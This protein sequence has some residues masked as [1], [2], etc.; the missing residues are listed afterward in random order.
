ML[1]IQF[2]TSPGSEKF[3][4]LMFKLSAETLP[5]SGIRRNHVLISFP[6]AGHVVP[7]PVLVFVNCFV[8][9]VEA[10]LLQLG[11]VSDNP[12]LSSIS[13]SLT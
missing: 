2:R 13:I 3:I 10:Q 7:T 9:I 5:D 4:E 6:K 8:M 12:I 11:V 1:S